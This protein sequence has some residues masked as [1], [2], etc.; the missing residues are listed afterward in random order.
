MIFNETIHP[1]VGI[2]VDNYKR[3][4]FSLLTLK[5]GFVGCFM[6][7]MCFTSVTVLMTVYFHGAYLIIF[8]KTYC[9]EYTYITSRAH[10]YL[11]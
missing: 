1:R 3:G 2:L 6:C 7:F 4:Q 5:P 10:D 8:H 11:R 9:A